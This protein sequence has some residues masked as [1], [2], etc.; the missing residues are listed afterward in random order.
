[1]KIELNKA[2]AKEQMKAQLALMQVIDPELGVNI[3]DLGLVYNVDCSR[4]SIFV[5][6]MTFSTPH[7]PLGDA[8][9][10]GVHHAM[11]HAFP[12]CLIQIDIVWEPEWNF[13]MITEAGKEALGIH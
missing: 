1:M 10:R 5:V 6:T 3:I 4:S 8:I 9:Q 11:S 12:D 13:D 2:Y 7:C